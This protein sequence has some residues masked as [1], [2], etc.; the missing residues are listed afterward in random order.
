VA[1]SGGV[2]LHVHRWDPP[3]GAPRGGDA[4]LVHGLASNARLW[5]G[6]APILA[7]AG[8]RVFAIDLRAHGTSDAP[9]GGYDTATAADDVAAVAGALRV[10]DALVVGQ[11]WGGN[12]VVEVAVRHPAT[13]G[14]LALLD[15]G[16]ISLS[17][18]FD[19][20]EACEGALRPPDVDGR[21]VADL[22][23]IMRTAHPGWANW[24]IDA[25]V[26]SLAVTP[27]GTLRRPLSIPHHMEIVRSMWDDPPQ[28]H[29]PQV[30]APVLLMPAVS[31]DPTKAA[32]RLAKLTAATAGLA[33]A[34][35]LPFPGG[36]HDLHAQQP[37][38]VAAA[39]LDFAEREEP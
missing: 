17:T 39:L 22:A 15:G 5:D 3:A 35:M 28:A 8:Y 23:R 25:T 34:T 11:S 1:V 33:R 13:V 20:W 30:T 19:S 4:V 24:A 14:R 31:A 9:S 16:W 6:V 10:R 21:A 12:V 26:A 2:G 37:H 32:A 29:Y 18:E 38:R 27:E 36:D 7:A